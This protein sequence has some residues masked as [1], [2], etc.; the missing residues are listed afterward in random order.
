MM[1]SIDTKKL[2][3]DIEDWQRIIA[4]KK[5]SFE[6]IKRERG[7]VQKKTDDF[8][9]AFE[10]VGHL[11]SLY[12]EAVKI[13]KDEECE[14]SELQADKLK[15]AKAEE[16]LEQRVAEQKSFLECHEILYDKSLA[17]QLTVHTQTHEVCS[18]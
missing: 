1:D 5:A 9:R 8:K 10:E 16:Q 2:K 17:G 7:K 14:L 3:K 15:M 4:T 13:I 6:S 18:S 11:Q 12:D